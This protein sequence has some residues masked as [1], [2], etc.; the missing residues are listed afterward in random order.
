MEPGFDV[1]QR[2]QRAQ[3]EDDRGLHRGA[4]DSCSWDRP[5]DVHAPLKAAVALQ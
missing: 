5:E 3:R 1:E 2:S 4:S